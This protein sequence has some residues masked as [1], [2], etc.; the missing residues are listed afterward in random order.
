MQ[1]DQCKSLGQIILQEAAGNAS[2]ADSRRS[3]STS[4][5]RMCLWFW[6]LGSIKRLLKKIT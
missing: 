6:M 2:R 3:S 4:L 5:W 1:S